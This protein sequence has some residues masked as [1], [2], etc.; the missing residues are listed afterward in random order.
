MGYVP[1]GPKLATMA[2][3]V[4]G[5]NFSLVDAHTNAAA[6]VGQTVPVLSLERSTLCVANFT[7]VS[8]TGIYRLVVDGLGTSPPFPI[9]INAMN[10]PFRMAMAAFYMARCGQDVPP[11]PASEELVTVASSGRPFSHDICHLRDGVV[12]LKHTHESTE[13]NVD[14]SGGWHDAGDYGKYSV[15]T[16]FTLGML[17]YGW[18]HFEQRMA[19]ADLGLPASAK[20]PVAD[21]LDEVRWGMAWLLKM[22]RPDGLVYHKLTGS[23]FEGFGEL[24]DGDD[25]TRY[26]SPWGTA[27]TGDLA[28]TGA[29]CYRVFAKHDPAFSQACLAAARRAYAALALHPEQ[30]TPDLSAFGTGTYV[31]ADPLWDVGVRIWAATEM[32]ESTR[33]L[34]YLEEAERLLRT[35][36]APSDSCAQITQPESSGSCKVSDQLDWDDQRNLGALR[37][38][39]LSSP[40][41]RSQELYSQVREQLALVVD[42]YARTSATNPYGDPLGGYTKWGIN[43]ELARQSVMLYGAELVLGKNATLEATA[44]NTLSLLFGRNRWGRSFVT[45]LGDWP[46]AHPHHRPSMVY[47]ESWPGM[48]VGGPNG[49]YESWSDG[50]LAFRSN[51]V[52]INWNCGLVYATARYYQCHR[53][54]DEALA[55]HASSARQPSQPRAPRAPTV[56]VG[57][58]SRDERDE[59]PTEEMVWLGNPNRIRDALSQR[60]RAALSLEE[61][62][63]LTPPEPPAF[64]ELA[65]ELE[66]QGSPAAQENDRRARRD[67]EAASAAAQAAA[68]ALAASSASPA[69]V[70]SGAQAAAAIADSER[71][72]K[73]EREAE[74]AEAAKAASAAAAAA[75][76]EAAKAASLQALAA[77]AERENRKR[78]DRDQA[79]DSSR[80]GAADTQAGANPP[81]SLRG[82]T[83][84]EKAASEVQRDQRSRYTPSRAVLDLIATHVYDDPPRP[85]ATGSRG[86]H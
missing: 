16:A 20:T 13:A 56:R 39:T 67:R 33:E 42:M 43:G 37:Y 18:E 40:A 12:D 53:G 54:A 35:L 49:G 77:A 8:A 79:A 17:M 52:A 15:N 68:A 27:A 76:A 14:G 59:L 5:S 44:L 32:F 3:S 30:Q 9:G 85:P 71:K 28:A 55:Q 75:K 66:V 57:R 65:L 31:T 48:L 80:K 50:W 62:A 64:D 78:R 2:M 21:Y 63:D 83:S 34:P 81:A 60:E 1:Y 10:R 4:C 84:D 58:S 73:R 74:A 26:F 7:S 61:A 70:P 19:C 41:G 25:A 23:H 38:L 45:K 47:A 22:Q 24:S 29:Q 11:L 82:S 6:L 51:E 46:A 69:A 72:R 86:T 36:D